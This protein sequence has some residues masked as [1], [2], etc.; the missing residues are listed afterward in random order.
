MLPKYYLIVYRGYKI[1]FLKFK[2]IGRD[3]LENGVSISLVEKLT[4]YFIQYLQPIPPITL[5][6]QSFTS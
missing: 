1:V 6:F 4:S 2:E 5:K 3:Q